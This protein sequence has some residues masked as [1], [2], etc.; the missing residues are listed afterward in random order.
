LNCEWSAVGPHTRFDVQVLVVDVAASRPRPLDGK[1]NL[2][3][4]DRDG[5]WKRAEPHRLRFRLYSVAVLQ[6][7]YFDE[8]LV[9]NQTLPY[10]PVLAR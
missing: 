10:R 6:R 8:S 5:R 3:D 1:S 4:L 9:S 2:A 7:S